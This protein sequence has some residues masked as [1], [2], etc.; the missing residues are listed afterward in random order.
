MEA[1]PRPR[2]S[3]FARSSARFIYASYWLDRLYMRF[4]SARSVMVLAFASDEVLEAHNSFSYGKMRPVHGLFDWEKRLVGQY[5]PPPPAHILIGAAGLGREAFALAEMG[6]KVS[7]F[8]PV[9]QLAAQ[10]RSVGRSVTPA[11]RVYRGAYQ[12]LP[13]LEGEQGSI[14]HDLRTDQPF[15]AGVIGWGSFSHLRSDAERVETLRRFGE[16][17]HGPIL[18]SFFG[19]G[20]QDGR[21]AEGYEGL[22]G[23]IRRLA[24]RRGMSRFV[25][26]GGYCRILSADDVDRFA[27]E[28]GLTVPEKLC[29]QEGQSYA[30]FFR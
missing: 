30:V 5:F 12:D 3:L 23:W 19:A 20:S 22:R 18:A 10:M 26:R 28:A 29:Y 17:T 7:A 24:A 11:V 2:P 25:M 21:S 16:I 6:Y 4:D 14:V 8:E 9:D 1:L 15:D 13:L 27:N